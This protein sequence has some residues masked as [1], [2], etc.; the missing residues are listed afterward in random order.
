MIVGALILLAVLAW[1]VLTMSSQPLV[2]NTGTATSTEDTLNE[3][4]TPVIE[5]SAGMGTGSDDL[6]DPV[7]SDHTERE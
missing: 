3:I 5:E 2:P 1:V 7:P 6:I 4:T